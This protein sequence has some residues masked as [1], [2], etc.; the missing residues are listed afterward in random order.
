MPL[1]ELARIDATE[2]SRLTRAREISCREIMRFHWERI[3]AENPEFNALVNLADPKELFRQADERD[4]E[5]ARGQWRGW[6]HGMPVAIKDTS[7]AVDFPTTKG[8]ALLASH[9]PTRDS[10]MVERMRRAGCIVVGKSNVSE[11]ALGSHTFNGLFG[12]TRNAWDKSVSAGGSSGGAAVAVARGM[13]PVADGSDLMGSL[14][15]P[16]AWNGIYALRPTQ[17]RVPQGPGPDIWTEQLG[18]SG[19]M[20]RTA[21]DLGNLL[22][23]QA[24]HDPRQPLSLHS[25]FDFDDAAEPDP[26]EALRGLRVGWLGDLGGRLAMQRGVMEAC[27]SALSRL[28]GL[29]AV[30][31][32]VDLGFDVE[33]LWQCWLKLRSAMI[34]ARVEPLL[35]L[36][37]A[38]EGIKPEALWEYEISRSL[39][40]REFILASQTRSRLYQRMRAMFADWDALALPSC[41]V[42]P[43][44]IES[45]WPESIEGRPMDTYHRWMEVS[46]YATLA[47]SP[48]VAMPAGFHPERGWPMG[49]QFMG[50]HG[51]D[52]ELIRIARA[53]ER[54]A[55][56]ESRAP[57]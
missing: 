20:G 35:A 48:A 29:G 33:E 49:I 39:S 55:A 50:A 19:P 27:E 30:V 37:G 9:M 32:R 22:S 16:A 31:E 4:A 23:V 24:G 13:L 43:F 46:I 36:P 1:A 53:Y 40:Y 8:S 54:G 10:I 28:A 2:L 3:E 12:A 26:R 14:R 45:R 56:P 17:G 7:D 47:G 21:R 5:I 41:Q 57:A 42:W 51:A 6:L 11:L 25:K 38:R 15:N 44:P 34:G 52:A 18:A